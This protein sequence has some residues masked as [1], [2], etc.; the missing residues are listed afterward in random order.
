MPF[1]RFKERH[2]GEGP[3]KLAYGALFPEGI[4]GRRGLADEREQT[5]ELVGQIRGLDWVENL[6]SMLQAAQRPLTRD[7][8]HA[9]RA[10]LTQAVTDQATLGDAYDTFQRE[11]QRLEQ[12]NPADQ[13]QLRT[14]SAQM[15][16]AHRYLLSGNPELE[17]AGAALSAKV[18]DAQQAYT[19]TNEAQRL[20]LGEQ[21][22]SRFQALQ[23]DLRSESLPYQQQ[24]RAWAA[25]NAALQE[26]S[27]AGDLALVYGAMHVIEPGSAVQQGE[28]ANAANAAGVP[29]LAITAYNRLLRGGERLTPQE[30]KQFYNLARNI[31]ETANGEQLERNARAV[32]AGRDG[33]IGEPYLRNLMQPIA[34][35]G[36]QRGDFGTVPTGEA[37]PSGAETPAGVI[38][39]T[40]IGIG[41]MYQGARRG[42]S[43][44]FEALLGPR[45]ERPPQ[46][47]SSGETFN[48][49]P[50]ERDGTARGVYIPRF[51]RR[52]PTND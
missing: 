11:Q 41:D 51:L 29:D 32:A 30:R 35:L 26:N 12:V 52:R 10:A 16:I 31:M 23:D 7:Q 38:R 17:K 6:D 49:V 45:A 40:A 50:I 39:D 1:E 3:F 5:D 44:A 25:V 34:P 22:W 46:P 9:V 18:L 36:E 28:L 14:M 48:G 20:A 8:H 37:Q 24:A 19:T 15:D 2:G 13:E 4:I 27:A 47:P 42:V 33:E 43:N 21:K